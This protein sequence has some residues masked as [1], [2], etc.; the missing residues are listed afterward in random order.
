M[1][2]ID[3]NDIPSMGGGQPVK[4]PKLSRKKS[5]NKAQ[6]ES[7]HKKREHYIIKNPVFW[8]MTALFLIFLA[9]SFILYFVEINLEDTYEKVA[10]YFSADIAIAAC[11][12]FLYLA[13]N[14]K[15]NSN[16]V[17]KIIFILLYLALCA[18]ILSF[19]FFNAQDNFNL[20]SYYFG[21]SYIFWIAFIFTTLGFII[22]H[23]YMLLFKKENFW[24]E[25]LSAVSMIIVPIGSAVL[26]IFIPPLI[27]MSLYKLAKSLFSGLR[28]SGYSS[29]SPDEK[30][31]TFTNEQGCQ[32]TVYSTDGVHFTDHQSNHW[33]S[34]DGGKTMYEDK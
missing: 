21:M 25:F 16:I 9:S 28:G 20:S 1:N 7:Y 22:F 8:I 13:I 5:N 15:I 26:F 31:Y 2:I 34:D 30:E 19:A 24:I 6:K 3:D 29:S 18:T 23:S 17:L 10:R 4:K 27:V 14:R 33:I 11:S 32:Q 12:Y